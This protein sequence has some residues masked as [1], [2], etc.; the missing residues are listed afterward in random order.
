M[1]INV[2]NYVGG[3]FIESPSE[4][5]VEVTTPHTGEII[6]RVPLSTKLEVDQAVQAAD[7]AFGDWSSKT[8]KARVQIMM[9]FH[10]L[11][12]TAYAN[13][14]RDII[15]KEHGKTKSEAAAE[16]AKGLETFE[17]AIS[18]PQLACGSWLEVSRGVMCRD[19]RCPLGVVVSI[20]PL[21]VQSL[22]LINTL[23]L[24]TFHSW[25]HFGPSGML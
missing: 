19:E 25:F 8:V 1:I 12:S 9:R 20:V 7:T 4:H 23:S 24:V 22:A 15:V 17:Y 18:M 5:H 6:A 14:L 3:E 2:K 16:I 10:Y 13:E 11:I 21:Y